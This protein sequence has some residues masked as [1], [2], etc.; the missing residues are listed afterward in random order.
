MKKLLLSL[1]AIVLVCLVLSCN[2]GA[3]MANPSSNG[4]NSANPL[5]PLDSA[6]FSWGGEDAISLK[7]D[8]N[9]YHSDSANSYFYLDTG[10]YNV[11]TGVFGSKRIMLR[12]SNIYK[13]NAYNYGYLNTLRMGVWYDSTHPYYSYYGNVGQVYI[14]ENKP[15]RIT[16]KFYFQAQDTFGKNIVNISEGYFNIAKY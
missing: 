2:N 4:N 11:I 6:G 8:G 3:Y 15:S 16:G 13:N 14:L 7:V 5:A 12:M 1:S 9:Y 10:G